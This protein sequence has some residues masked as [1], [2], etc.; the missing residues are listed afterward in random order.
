[1]L[2]TA[3]ILSLPQLSL[4]LLKWK[5]DSN[6]NMLISYDDINSDVSNTNNHIRLVFDVK[7]VINDENFPNSSF[8]AK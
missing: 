6:N 7:Y 8:L 5:A 1:V 3:G 2:Q 4:G